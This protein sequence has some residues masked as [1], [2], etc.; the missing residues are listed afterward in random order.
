MSQLASQLR[1]GQPVWLHQIG[2]ARPACTH[3]PLR[4]RRTCDVV[5]VGGGITGALVA[6]T[7]ATEGIPVILLEGGCVGSG[8]TLASSA[9]LQEPDRELAHLTT[10][11]GH[12]AARRI[13]RWR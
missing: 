3:P 2:R 4:A 10:Q 8:S 11:Y 6:L 1:H 7:F 13:S 5:I 12:A 9:L